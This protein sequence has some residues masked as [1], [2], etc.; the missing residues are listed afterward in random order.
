M[1]KI[2]IKFQ[3]L[4]DNFKYGSWRRCNDGKKLKSCIDDMSLIAD[5][6]L[7]LQNL[8]NQYL[9]LKQEKDQMLV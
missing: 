3:K 5:K 2:N 1:L 4:K 7:L 9:I 8:K 6:N